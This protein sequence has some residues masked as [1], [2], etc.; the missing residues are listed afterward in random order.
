M[1]YRWLQRVWYEGALSGLVLV[2]LSWLFALVSGV[3]RWAYRTGV[4]RSHD[5]GVPVVVVGNIT[6]GGTGKTPLTLWL[7]EQLAARGRRVGIAL[8]GYGGTASH[9]RLVSRE[10]T[11]QDVGDEAALIARRQI[12][13]VA[14]GHDR[15]AVAELLRAQGCNLIIADDGLQHLR[16][17]RQFEIVVVDAARGLG[18]GRL[19]PAGPLRE[20]PSRLASVDAVV[21]NGAGGAIEGL[22][23]Q[24][25]AQDAVSVASPGTRRPLTSFAGQEVH[26]VAAIGHPE[27]FFRT[28]CEHGLRPIEH[29]FPDHAALRAS[30]IQFEGDTAVLMTEKDAVKCVALANSRHWF[31][32]VQASFD[33]VEGD[34]LVSRVKAL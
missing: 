10:A 32:P 16:L 1:I 4:F 31:V 2:P 23:M 29:P 25:R 26:A 3:R 20:A 33:R 19:L 34:A 22:R 17:R 13:T 27:R 9:P 6:V 11:A 21:V 24:L 30:D 5:V 8:R 14:V 28:L 15:V 7:A 12:A 18:N